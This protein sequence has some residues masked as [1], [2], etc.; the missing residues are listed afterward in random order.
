M[1]LKANPRWMINRYSGDF[2]TD[3]LRRSKPGQFVKPLLHIPDASYWEAM[4][5]YDGIRDGTVKYRPNPIGAWEDHDTRVQADRSGRVTLRGSAINKATSVTGPRSSR[6]QA[7]A[8]M[9][10]G[11]PER[12]RERRASSNSRGGGVGSY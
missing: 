10:R 11:S 3:M 2:Y 12:P 5:R 1:W 6:S 9:R 8:R 4:G 7:P